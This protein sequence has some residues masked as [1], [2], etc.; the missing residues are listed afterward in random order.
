MTDSG[1]ITLSVAQIGNFEAAHST[2]N[3]LR[4][5]ITAAGHD[6]TPLEEA[7]PASFEHVID[8]VD[9]YDVVLWT[10]TD[11]P[12]DDLELRRRMLAAARDAGVPTVGY[13]LDL[14]HGLHRHGQI[15]DHPFFTCELVITADGGH[16][17]EFAAAG[18]NHVWFPPGVSEFECGGGTATDEYAADIAFVGS[19]RPG[20]HREHQHRPDL[21]KFL[22]KTYG[23]R[24]RFWPA[25]GQPAVRGAALRDLYASTKI[26]VGDSCLAGR[27][28]NYW[29]DRIPETLGRGGFL[30]H[31]Y[32]DGIEDHFTDGE[33]LRL[34]QIGDWAELR[35]LTD[36]Y[37]EHDDERRRIAAQGRLHV[38]EHHTYTVR[39]RQLVDLLADRGMLPARQAVA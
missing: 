16:E 19:W 39:I 32:V 12:G 20:Y 9:A 26:N 25:Q 31:P 21:L 5:A 1:G 37:L 29:S 34:W 18:V 3:E 11:R 7:D 8:H 17:P 35:R 28:S 38:L 10:K 6:G 4:K 13:H 33:H 27:I 2:E 14:W 36:F 15:T 22:R 23:D 30:L 24:A